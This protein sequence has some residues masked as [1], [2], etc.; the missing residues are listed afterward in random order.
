MDCLSPSNL[1][2]LADYTEPEEL[3]TVRKWLADYIGEVAVVERPD[4]VIGYVKLK[5]DARYN[6][7]AQDALPD[8]YTKGIR[9]DEPKLC[10]TDPKGA[11]R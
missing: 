4:G 1:A 8:L 6:A 7:G 10:E 9:L 5:A 3:E 2:R 11:A